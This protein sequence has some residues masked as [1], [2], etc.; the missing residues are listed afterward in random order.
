M[1]KSPSL[2]YIFVCMQQ[3][4]AAKKR[5]DYF[6]NCLTAIHHTHTASLS[7][8]AAPTLSGAHTPGKAA[9]PARQVNDRPLPRDQSSPP[10]EDPTS[11]FLASSHVAAQPSAAGQ[12]QV[13]CMLQGKDEDNPPSRA[14]QAQER[15]GQQ[16]SVLG[17]DKAVS[18]GPWHVEGKAAFAEAPRAQD[19]KAMR[20]SILGVDGP[21]PPGRSSSALS[22]RGDAVRP[23]WL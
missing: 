8:Q 16:P 13:A 21:A 7:G 20:P 23:V 17:L 4:L 1:Q 18:T 22:A 11:R 19:R 15:D 14:E 3:S 12:T 10:A 6:K 9:R 5:V 2:A